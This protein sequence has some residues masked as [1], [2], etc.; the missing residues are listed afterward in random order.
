MIDFLCGGF[1]LHSS[2]KHTGTRSRIVTSRT[3]EMRKARRRHRSNEAARSGRVPVPDDSARASRDQRPTP[4]SDMRILGATVDHRGTISAQIRLARNR[5]VTRRVIA[6]RPSSSGRRRSSDNSCQDTAA[7]RR[8]TF[9]SSSQAASLIPYAVYEACPSEQ[10]MRHE[11][12]MENSLL[13]HGPGTIE[14]S[15]APIEAPGPWGTRNHARVTKFT[16]L[17]FGATRSEL[18]RAAVM[19]SRSRTTTILLAQ[20]RSRDKRSRRVSI[21]WNHRPSIAPPLRGAS[22]P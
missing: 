5:H 11:R 18:R 10:V 21:K 7:H 3:R 13:H 4:A 19:T 1:L 6:M 20:D 14:C 12:V 8:S 15:S 16:P 9:A 22:P 2:R 17:P